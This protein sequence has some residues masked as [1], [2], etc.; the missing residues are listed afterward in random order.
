MEVRVNPW[1]GSVPPNEVKF[2]APQQLHTY[3]HPRHHAV[4]QEAAT[5]RPERKFS[6][7]H[8]HSCRPS[9][10]VR[11]QHNIGHFP[12]ASC[13]EAH[14][15]H[16]LHYFQCHSYSKVLPGLGPANG[17]ET[18]CSTALRCNPTRSVPRLCLRSTP[19]RWHSVSSLHRKN[20]P[21]RD[22]RP[23][24]DQAAKHDFTPPRAD[25]FDMFAR[26]RGSFTASLIW[27]LL[28]ISGFVQRR[29]RRQHSCLTLVAWTPTSCGVLRRLQA[30]Y[31]LLY[32]VLC[33]CFV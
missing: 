17:S 31:L 8:T 22:A 24:I 19:M 32:S 23:P 14:N 10:R 20:H 27:K 15:G 3:A 16:I 21:K 1:P 4:T 33:G 7:P 25:R 29:R 5:R 12:A 26:L 11:L 30:G 6:R 2:H 9:H 18:S 28:L 13:P